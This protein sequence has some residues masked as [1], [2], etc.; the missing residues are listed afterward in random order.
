MRL[1]NAS[2]AN[3]PSSTDTRGQ[4]CH[5]IRTTEQLITA[6]TVKWTAETYDDLGFHDNATN[7]DR[8]TI[9][10]NVSRVLLS[11]AC[12]FGDDEVAAGTVDRNYMEKNGTSFSPQIN[13][14]QVDVGSDVGV[15]EPTYNFNQVLDVVAGDYFTC[16]CIT[17]LIAG[18]FLD[19]DR[20]YF[21]CIVIRN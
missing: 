5:L 8:I 2:V 4:G 11:G 16:V 17:S 10:A 3:P 9:P 13:D 7:T 20:S 19:V 14:W 6:E 12:N 18:K 15:H 1:R 21:S